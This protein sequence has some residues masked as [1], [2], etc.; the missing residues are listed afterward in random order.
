LDFQS[1]PDI[2]EEEGQGRVVPIEWWIKNQDIDSLK[3]LIS[4][5]RILPV[6]DE[7]GRI[8]D[9]KVEEWRQLTFRQMLGVIKWLYTTTSYYATLNLAEEPKNLAPSIWDIFF[10]EIESLVAIYFPQHGNLDI[11]VPEFNEVVT[12]KL[13][14]LLRYET[15]GKSLE[16]WLLEKIGRS[17]SVQEIRMP[18]KEGGGKV[19]WLFGRR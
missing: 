17:V 6:V 19:G 16:G 3:Q 4:G 15:S 8:V 18:E 10:D 12:L 13:A 2:G 11:V 14:Q 5:L 9:I 1:I 7:D